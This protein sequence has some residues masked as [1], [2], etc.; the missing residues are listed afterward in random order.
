MLPCRVGRPAT[1]C[2]PLSRSRAPPR[3]SRTAAVRGCLLVLPLPVAFVAPHRYRWWLLLTPAMASLPP[4]RGTRLPPQFFAPPSPADTGLLG[5]LGQLW[6]HCLTFC[7]SLEMDSAGSDGSSGG[8]D[9]ARRGACR[10]EGTCRL[11]SGLCSCSGVTTVW[12]ALYM[13]RDV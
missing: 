5:V 4:V 12:A 3:S 7:A 9:R 11:L 2:V 8:R 1:A 13:Y 10:G 6:T